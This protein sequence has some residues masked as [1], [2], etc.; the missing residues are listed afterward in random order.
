MAQEHSKLLVR[1][2]SAL[3]NS[4]T[5][6][7]P[8]PHSHSA[9]VA[10][11]AVVRL[12]PIINPVF[13]DDHTSAALNDT[14]TAIAN[15]H[16]QATALSAFPSAASRGK[17]TEG[18]S[19]TVTLPMSLPRRFTFDLG[20]TTDIPEL[21]RG[22]GGGE[23][24]FRGSRD[25][26]AQ[27]QPQLSLG[28]RGSVSA[29]VSS[30]LPPGGGVDADHEISVRLSLPSAAGNRCPRTGAATAGVTTA[31]HALDRGPYHAAN[32]QFRAQM[33]H[34]GVHVSVVRDWMLI[35]IAAITALALAVY[36][37]VR[38]WYLVTGRVNEENTYV[39]YSWIVL[40]AE[41]AIGTLGFYCRG[42]TLR[43]EPAF[44]PLTASTLEKVAKVC[45]VY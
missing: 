45:A 9:P 44:Y 22:P 35:F 38:V 20:R 43:Q 8:Q 27:M 1:G 34:F 32:A 31:S 40:A 7:V 15:A 13:L 5:C 24:S 10:S 18:N 3:T 41:V 2:A 25:L 19:N 30:Q 39:V 12:N 11:N 29:L 36:V 16:T 14:A 6:A 26:G 4:L 17:D 33:P 42:L 21:R 37:G 28:S 23:L